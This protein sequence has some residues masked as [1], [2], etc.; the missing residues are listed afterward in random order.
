MDGVIRNGNKKI[1]LS[2]VVFNKLNQMNKKYVILTNE[3]RKEP[4][5]IR[6]D[7]K[8]MKL[9]IRDNVPIISDPN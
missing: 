1:G 9:N 3:C 4:R 6:Q 2:D 8:T 5:Q 7:L